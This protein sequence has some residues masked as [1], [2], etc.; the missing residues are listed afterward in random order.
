MSIAKLDLHGVPHE[1]ADGLV[2]GF[3]NANWKPDQEL[4]I[5]TGHSVL[6]KNIVKKALNFYDVEVTEGDPRNSGYIRILT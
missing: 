2:H 1:E 6:M 3:I 4:H 5:I